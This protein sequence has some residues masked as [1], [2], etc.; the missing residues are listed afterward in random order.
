MTDV[1]HILT[2]KFNEKVLILIGIFDKDVVPILRIKNIKFD[3]KIF[4]LIKT[5]VD[6]I[7]TSGDPNLFIDIFREF[8]F[9]YKERIYK[10]DLELIRDGKM[11]DQI[12]DKI[13]SSK[14]KSTLAEKY[15]NP[16]EIDDVIDEHRAKLHI[17]L[18]SKI[19]KGFDVWNE[20]S[21]ETHSSIW[22]NLKLMTKICEKL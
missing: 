4:N 17:N 9:D 13:K 16:A 11:F 20:L 7:A 6:H 15:I 22:Q 19:E 1:S 10:E 14:N 3:V 5:G 12:F 8:I 21:Q 18:S 2:K